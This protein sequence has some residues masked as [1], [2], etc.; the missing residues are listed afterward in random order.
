MHVKPYDEMIAVLFVA[1]VYRLSPIAQWSVYISLGWKWG[2]M[3]PQCRRV[4]SSNFCRMSLDTSDARATIDGVCDGESGKHNVYNALVD[5]VP[6][7][8][9]CCWYEYTVRKAIS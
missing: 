2:T 8:L 1:V 7:Q 3:P 4:D 9:V 6:C 5:S